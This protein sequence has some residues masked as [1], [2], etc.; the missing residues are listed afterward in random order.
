MCM[1]QHIPL[2]F[3]LGYGHVVNVC[4]CQFAMRMGM[5]V[6][7]LCA[8]DHLAHVQSVYEQVCMTQHIPRLVDL[9]HG[10]R[11]S[12]LKETDRPCVRVCI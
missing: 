5:R 3:P 2:L 4:I 8:F 11:Y 1:T 6:R 12:M 7:K 10:L 9:L